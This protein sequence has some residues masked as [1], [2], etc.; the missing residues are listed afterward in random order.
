[1]DG[2]VVPSAAVADRVRAIENELAS[3][4]KVTAEPG[5]RPKLKPTR[6]PILT[7]T[8]TSAGF[9][10][11]KERRPVPQRKNLCRYLAAKKL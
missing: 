11:E 10:R 8:P 5:P 7:P 6:I 3:S 4:V 2:V 1:M 9:N